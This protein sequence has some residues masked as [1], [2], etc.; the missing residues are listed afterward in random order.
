MRQKCNGDISTRRSQRNRI[1][2]TSVVA[3][4][5]KTELGCLQDIFMS[6]A[7]IA[8]KASRVLDLAKVIVVDWARLSYIS[9][10]IRLIFRAILATNQNGVFPKV[11]FLMGR[12]TFSEKLCYVSLTDFEGDDTT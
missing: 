9:I 4:E 3:W 8:L 10:P 6:K 1:W 12:G 2:S 7:V 5:A 11:F